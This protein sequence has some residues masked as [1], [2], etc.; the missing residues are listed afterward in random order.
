MLD[1]E[2]IR[3]EKRTDSGSVLGLFGLAESSTLPAT[4]RAGFATLT[5]RSTE[6]PQVG[7]TADCVAPSLIVR[8]NLRTD[9]AKR[10]QI[11]S[12]LSRQEQC[13][14][15]DTL[16]A[17]SKFKIGQNFLKN[18]VN[19]E[20]RERVN[21]KEILRL[22]RSLRMTKSV[23]HFL[24][25]LPTNLLTFKPA[26][27]LAETLITLGIIGVVAALTI[28]EL[29]TAYKAHQLRSQFLKSY[30]TVQ[31]VFKQME[32][33]DVSLDPATYNGST[34]YKEFSKYLKNVQLCSGVSTNSPVIGCYYPKTSTSHYKGISG[35]Y[36]DD[37]QILLLDGT[38][39]LFEN[40]VKTSNPNIFVS[41][42]L[43]GYLTKP[44]IAGY[45]LFTFEF[46]DGE[47]RTMGDKGTKFIGNEYCDFT[48]MM[49]QQSSSQNSN[50]F[51]IACAHKAKTESDYF[52]KAI[53]FLK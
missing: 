21:S 34:F 39:L 26:F 29:M 3:V 43:N 44:N 11:A 28:P 53:K 18:V 33:D 32:A 4:L 7:V 1:T 10:V 51:G 14:V 47:L 6:N 13:S 37:G 17:W 20:I 35:Y 27:T 50:N 15:G 36:L 45:D 9:K 25:S 23:N 16:R 19:L 49:Q 48:K 12:R 42:D 46:V 38:L 22:L 5:R 40:T 8:A 30:S 24:T 41:V 31:Q 2:S 52:K